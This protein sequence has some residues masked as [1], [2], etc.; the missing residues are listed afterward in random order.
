ML[1]I[2]FGPKMN[3]GKQELL[4]A[5]Y[6]I[7]FIVYDVE[8]GAYETS[9]EREQGGGVKGLPDVICQVF[10]LMDAMPKSVTIMDV[11]PLSRIL[12]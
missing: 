7:D 8:G 1:D 3:T 5:P 2:N 4:N 10:L 9:I 6:A 11:R 12:N